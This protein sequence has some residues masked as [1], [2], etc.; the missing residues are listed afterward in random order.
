[1][2]K[3]ARILAARIRDT[4]PIGVD[5]FMSAA[6]FHPEH[7]YYRTRDPLGARGDFVTAPE[8]SQMFGEL[9]G[10]WCAETWRQMGAPSSFILAELGPG[11]GTLMADA[12]RAARLVP[13]FLDAMTLHLVE[14]SP[15]LRAAQARALAPLAPAWH[16]RAE[17]LPDGPLLLVANEF[18]D[19]LPI[20]QFVRAEDG[21]HE[22]RVGIDGG[23]FAYILSEA[24]HK[25]DFSADVLVSSVAEISPQAV[26]LAAWLDGRLA[27]QGGAALFIDYGH[28]KSGFGDTLQA[29]RAHRRHDPLTDPGE[30]D[31][32][33]HVDFAVFARAATAAGAR[34]FGPVEQ[35]LFL[36]RLGIRERADRLIAN[37]TATQAAAIERGYRRLVDPDAMGSLFKVLALAHPALTLA[38]F[39]GEA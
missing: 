24:M 26:A 30:A 15:N 34:A 35:G 29:L 18:L 22:R 12:L 10:L 4:G 17:D 27:R 37:A 8:V 31:L 23:E 16:D 38:G 36:R 14:F 28:A 20:R 6:L 7:G 13:G 25:M 9:I 32:S 1:V 21:W 5:D 2:N 33:A 3:L 11:R 39:E 19:A